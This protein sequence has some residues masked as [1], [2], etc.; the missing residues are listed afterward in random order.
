MPTVMYLHGF[1]SSPNGTKANWIYQK[2]EEQGIDFLAPDL[3]VPTFEHLTVT[4]MTQRI[5]QAVENCTSEPIFLLGS[6]MGGFATLHFMNTYRNSAAKR[7]QKILLLAP[8]TTQ[9]SLFQQEDFLATWR[10]NGW[11]TI[12]HY[13]YGE[14]R[15]LSYEFAEDFQKHATNTIQ[16][17]VPIVIFHGKN[18][19]SVNPE[20]SIQFSEKHNNVQLRLVDSDH[21]LINQLDAI[22]DTMIEFFELNSSY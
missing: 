7:I 17:D 18:D 19:E 15:Q 4:A 13:A 14:T 6:S 9:A 3:N 16:V 21:S 5:A 10:K 11:T 12:E 20:S 1:A 8:V 22:W 2:C